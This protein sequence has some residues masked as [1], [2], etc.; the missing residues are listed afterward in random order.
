MEAGVADQMQSRKKLNAL[1]AVR[2]RS[3]NFSQACSFTYSIEFLLWT[4]VP[5][6]YA[7]QT[8]HKG[9]F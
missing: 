6:T 1:P 5:R 9:Y 2:P 4:T 8:V 7:G 3:S